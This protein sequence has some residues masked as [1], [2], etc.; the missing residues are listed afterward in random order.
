MA[1]QAT[2]LSKSAL[3]RLERTRITERYILGRTFLR[4]FGVAVVAYLIRAAIGDLAGQETTVTLSTALSVLADLKLTV[5]ISIAGGA[6]LWAFV[7]RRLRLRKTEAL[8]TRI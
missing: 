8:Q 7:E 1:A 4:V 2:A 5:A 3:E 6:G